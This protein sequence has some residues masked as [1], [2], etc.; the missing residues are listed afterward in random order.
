MT[1]KA[2]RRVGEEGE[3]R[4]A[5][6]PAPGRES[7]T[8]Q[9]TSQCD[10]SSGAVRVCRVVSAS[11]GVPSRGVQWNRTITSHYSTSAPHGKRPPVVPLVSVFISESS[12]AVTCVQVVVVK[13]LCAV[14]RHV[15]DS[16]WREEGR[17]NALRER[18]IVA[19]CAGEAGKA[20][21]VR[22]NTEGCVHKRA[23][24]GHFIEGRSLG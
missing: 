12:V 1:G 6:Q 11:F 8:S 10:S 9:P 15:S 21:Y 5:S 20:D 4:G 3:S 24:L 2:V 18:I 16:W 7:L 14:V 19:S 17:V 23:T 22:L 13:R